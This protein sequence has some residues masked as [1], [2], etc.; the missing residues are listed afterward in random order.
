MKRRIKIDILRLYIV[1]VSIITLG[2]VAN[3]FTIIRFYY[4]STIAICIYLIYKDKIV[5]SH[6]LLRIVASIIIGAILSAF[7][8]DTGLAYYRNI[9]LTSLIAYLVIS[10]FNYDYSKLREYIYI[11]CRIICVLGLINF[12]LFLIIPDSFVEVTNESNGYSVNTILYLFNYSH[13]TYHLFTRNQSVFWEPG[14]FQLVL[15][16][17]LFDILVERKEKFKKAVLPMALIVTTFSTTGLLIMTLIFAYWLLAIKKVR[18]LSSLLIGCVF[19]VA[20][21]PVVIDN[22]KEKVDDS[23]QSAAMRAFDY[24]MGIEIIKSYPLF[25]VGMDPENYYKKTK[26]VDIGKY[27]ISTFDIERNNTNTFIGIAT[28]FGLPVLFLFIFALYKQ[29]IYK[30]NRIFF[31]ILSIGLLSEPLFDLPFMIIICLSSVKL[32]F[33]NRRQLLIVENNGV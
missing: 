30:S 2:G 4:L 11:V 27:D 28:K 16:I 15:N 32:H 9:V 1:F 19:A 17:H 29:Q 25:G 26:G 22:V 13:H 20:L 6:K 23:N 24:Y 5:L 3:M 8:T 14:V 10:S 31:F 7:I 21:I 12:V 18:S 33:N